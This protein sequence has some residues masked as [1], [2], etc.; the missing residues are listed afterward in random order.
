[1]A[2]NFEIFKSKSGDL[3]FHLMQRTG[4]S[5]PAAR[6]TSRR[7]RATPKDNRVARDCELLPSKI[8]WRAHRIDYGFNPVRPRLA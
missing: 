5:S 1:M 3:R 4:R 7:L 2:A 6:A 8:G